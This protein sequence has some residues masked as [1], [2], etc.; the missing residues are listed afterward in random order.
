MDASFWPLGFSQA[1]GQ[2]YAYYE[3]QQVSIFREMM[4]VYVLADFATAY[5]MLLPV[6]PKP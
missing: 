6:E 5:A 3:R 4:D 1:F 2:V